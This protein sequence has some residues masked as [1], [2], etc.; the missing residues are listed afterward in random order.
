MKIDFSSLNY[1]AIGL[2]LLMSIVISMVWYSPILFGKPWANLTGQNMGGPPNPNKL[3][4]GIICNLAFIFAIALLIQA[5]GIQ[6][7]KSA[8][9]FS[10]IIG[11]GFL[12]A[13]NLPV[14]LYNG[15]KMKL[16]IID[17]GG[18]MFSIIIVSIIIAVWR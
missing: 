3:I 9:I 18:S 14:Y 4:I 5:T 11:I 10:F 8:L 2:S 12:L 16:L 6:G 17:M 15:L 13:V 7:I 1:Y